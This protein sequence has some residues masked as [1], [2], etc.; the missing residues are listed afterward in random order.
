VCQGADGEET[1]RT[2]S[3]AEE[4]GRDGAEESRDDA[5]AKRGTEKVDHHL[6]SSSLVTA[7]T[8]LLMVIVK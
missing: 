4:D 1:S 2:G 5:A 8:K 3:E 7:V 6:V